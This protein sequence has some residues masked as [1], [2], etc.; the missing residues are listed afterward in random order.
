MLDNLKM[1]TRVWPLQFIRAMGN[2]NALLPTEVSKWHLT[3][4]FD[5]IRDYHVWLILKIISH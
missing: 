3:A 1:F 2:R 4:L 5:S